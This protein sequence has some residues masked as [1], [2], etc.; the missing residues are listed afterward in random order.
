MILV[1][2]EVVKVIDTDLMLT[3]LWDRSLQWQG[4]GHINGTSNGRGVRCGQEQDSDPGPGSRPNNIRMAKV[5]G[6]AP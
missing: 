5:M 1:V 3:L 4:N 6:K 2:L